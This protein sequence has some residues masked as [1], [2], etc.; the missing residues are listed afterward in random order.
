[1]GARLKT[2]SGWQEVRLFDL[3]RSGAQFVLSRPDKVRDGTLTWL[4]IDAFGGAV[5]Q[6]GD[7]VGLEFDRV[8]PLPYLVETRKLAPGIVHEESLGADSD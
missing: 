2:V 5:W 8:I 1:M 4:R 3:S 6:K 7:R